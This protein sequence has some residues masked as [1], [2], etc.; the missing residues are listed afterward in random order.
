MVTA[1]FLRAVFPTF[2][3]NLTLAFLALDFLTFLVLAAILTAFFLTVSLPVAEL[4][5]KPA[6][7][8]NE[9]TKLTVPPA[10]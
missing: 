3:V 1:F 6:A 5:N 7:P 4:P 8:L 9:A 2:K 10:L